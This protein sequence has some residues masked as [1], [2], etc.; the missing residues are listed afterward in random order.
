MEQ[1]YHPQYYLSSKKNTNINSNKGYD[2]LEKKL[3]YSN[4]PA[5]KDNNIEVIAC[6]EAGSRE[7][8]KHAKYT[9][10]APFFKSERENS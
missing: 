2:M 3:K 6:K 4:N 8:H 5:K 7:T 10:G 9:V 1:R